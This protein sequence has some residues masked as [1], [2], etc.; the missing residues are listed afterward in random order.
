MNTLEHSEA[1]KQLQIL[2]E[3]LFEVARPIARAV[4]LRGKAGAQPKLPLNILSAEEGGLCGETDA[5]LFFPEERS[6]RQMLQAKRLCAQCALLETCMQQRFARP[7]HGIMGGL[8]D[9]ER[10]QLL[11][12]AYQELPGETAAA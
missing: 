10:G 1:Y 11:Q 3:T 7:G 6:P 9:K 8:T 4:A 5:E 2:N 12:E